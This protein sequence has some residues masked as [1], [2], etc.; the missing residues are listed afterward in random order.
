MIRANFIMSL[1]SLSIVLLSQPA[2]SSERHIP[3]SSRES[4]I[5]LRPNL[6]RFSNM[7]RHTLPDLFEQAKQGDQTAIE[8][9]LNIA[10]ACHFLKDPKNGYIDQGRG[11]DKAIKGA[12]E[13]VEKHSEEINAFKPTAEDAEIDYSNA[14]RVTQGRLYSCETPNQRQSIWKQNQLV[15]SDG[16]TFDGRTVHKPNTQTAISNAAVIHWDT[17]RILPLPRAIYIVLA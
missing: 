15:V 10:E 5:D 8:T 4:K 14:L 2:L 12:T 11:R 7:S 9:L 6:S 3:S 13:F 16:Y 17:L 1:A